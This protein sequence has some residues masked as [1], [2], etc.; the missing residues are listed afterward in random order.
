MHVSI[1]QFKIMEMQET[2]AI[3]LTCGGSSIVFV[4]AMHDE[5]GE[6]GYKKV[7]Q[8]FVRETDKLLVIQIELGCELEDLDSFLPE[9]LFKNINKMKLSAYLL[10]KERTGHMDAYNVKSGLMRMNSERIE[11]ADTKNGC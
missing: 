2:E 11:F 7:C 6:Q 1:E 4:A 3:A 5:T 10:L 8:I 9:N